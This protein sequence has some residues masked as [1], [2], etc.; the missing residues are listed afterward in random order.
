MYDAEEGKGG[1]L[2]EVRRWCLVGMHSM[3]LFA[4]ALAPRAGTRGHWLT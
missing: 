3:M 2:L 1:R 4:R